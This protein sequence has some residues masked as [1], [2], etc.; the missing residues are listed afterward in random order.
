MRVAL[1]LG[2][3]CEWAADVRTLLPSDVQPGEVI[4][5]G[6]VELSA[7]ALLVQVVVAKNETSGAGAGGGHKESSGV[8]EVQQT[9][10]RGSETAPVGGE[11]LG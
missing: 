1:A 9:G 4:E 6:G 3:G 7:G 5:H 2:V 10:W 11:I 8:A